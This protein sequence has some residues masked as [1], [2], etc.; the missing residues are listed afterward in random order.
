MDIFYQLREYVMVNEHVGLRIM[1]FSVQSWLVNVYLVFV[2][3][4]WESL[5]ACRSA[6]K[7]EI[8][9]ASCKGNFKICMKNIL[10]KH[11]LNK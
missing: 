6:I 10:G 2:P 5:P 1:L 8:Y 7:V 3:A 4:G 9:V 11:I